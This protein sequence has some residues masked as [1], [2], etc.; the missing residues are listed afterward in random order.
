MKVI[1]PSN[2]NILSLEMSKN[3]LGKQTTNFGGNN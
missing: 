1:F 3:F 2:K